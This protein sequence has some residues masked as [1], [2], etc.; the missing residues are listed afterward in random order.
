MKAHSHEN[1]ATA[2]IWKWGYS[3]YSLGVLAATE[4]QEAGDRRPPIKMSAET[5]IE[6]PLK[7]HY[8]P[9]VLQEIDAKKMHS[10]FQFELH[11]VFT[12][13]SFGFLN[14]VDQYRSVIGPSWVSLNLSQTTIMSGDVK[15]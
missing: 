15:F 2:V 7:S 1:L 12:N 3:R 9:V 4:L 11:S 14:W 6:D 5:P 13:T 8:R 10:T